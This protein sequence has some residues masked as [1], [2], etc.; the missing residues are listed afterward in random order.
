MAGHNKVSQSKLR[1]SGRVSVRNRRALEPRILLDAAAAE[2]VLELASPDIAELSEGTAQGALAESLSSLGAAQEAVIIDAAV[3]GADQLAASFASSG[4]HVVL[5][6]AE[7]DGVA[8]L[9]SA[10][11]NL[12]DLSTI[13]I[14]SHGSDG[15]IRL[16]N[17]L[18]NSE[19]LA[20]NSQALAGIG[21]SLS[22]GGDIR[23]YG[24]NVGETE[25]GR[26]FLSELATLS[27]ADV[28]ASDDVTG[29][30]GDW[31]LEIAEGDIAS[32]TPSLLGQYMGDL[33]L[34]GAASGVE[35][36][37]AGNQLG[38][39]TD[40]SGDWVVSGGNATGT[41]KVWRV[42]DAVTGG[43]TDGQVLPLPGT[44]NASFGQGVAIF[45]EELVVAA[46]T[47]GTD[48]RIYV[49]QLN[50][51]TDVWELKADINISLGGDNIGPWNGGYGGSQYIDI[52]NGRIIVGAPNEGNGTGRV[53]WFLDTS[54]DG[55][56]STYSSN[57]F[58]EPGGYSTNDGDNVRFGASLSIAGDYFVVG[59]PGA[60]T[61]NDGLG[62]WNNNGSN[63]GAAFIYSWS[64]SSAAAGTGPSATVTQRL[65]GQ[66]DVNGVGDG[67]LKENSRFGAAVDME[68]YGGKY[69]IVAGAPG[70]GGGEIYIYQTTSESIATL[71]GASNIYGQTT[72]GAADRYGSQV[73]VSQAR[74]LVGASSSVTLSNTDNAVWYY[75]AVDNTWTGLDTNNPGAN[76]N[77][78][79][80]TF[81]AAQLGATGADKPGQSIALLG[82]SLAAIGSYLD[83]DGGTN[84]G[85][86]IFR[87]MRT[88]FAIND[89]YQINEDTGNAS[90]NITGNDLWGSESLASVNFELVSGTQDG[91]GTFFWNGSTLE[92]DP[93][94]SY[95]YLAAGESV[96]VSIRYKLTDTDPMGT[97]GGTT[98]YYSTQGIVSFT[99]DGVN[100]PVTNGIG[101]PDIVVP[102]ANEPANSTTGSLPSDGTI[103]IRDNVFK[104]IDLSDDFTYT[105]AGVTTVSGTA[106]T[107]GTHLKVNP[108]SAFRTGSITYDLDGNSDGIADIAE[109]TVWDITVQAS[110]GVTTEFTTFRFTVARANE[111]PESSPIPNQAAVEDS[112]FS[113]DV[114]GYFT[115]PDLTP[116][117]PFYPEELTF[118]II[119]RVGP[120][121]DWLAISSSGVLSGVP[122]NDNALSGGVHTVTIRATDIFGNYTEQT[123][124]ITVANTND[125]PVLSQPI[126]RVVAEAGSGA[127]PFS[128]NVTAANAENPDGPFFEDID[129]T[130]DTITY[131]AYLLTS[132][133]EITAG[134]AGT[135]TGSW[136]RFNGTTFTGTPTDSLGTVFS[137]RLV[138]TDNHG[139]SSE[140]IFEVGV[141]PPVGDSPVV[142]D[143]GAAGGD[144]LGYSSTISGDGR[145]A[146][147]GMPGENNGNGAVQIFE[148]VAGTW[149]LRQTINTG[150]AAGSRFGLSVSL[151]YDGN[152]LVVGAPLEN[153][154][155]GAIYYYERA[156]TTFAAA[157]NVKAVGGQ[158]GERLG[159]SVAVNEAGNNVLAGAPLNDNA[160]GT[161]AGA[162]YWF[163]WNGTTASQ[164]RLATLDAGEA[165]AA[166]DMFGTSVAFNENMQVVGAARDDHSGAVDAG[167]VYVFTTDNGSFSKIFKAGTIRDA[168]YFGASVSVDS[169]AGRNSVLLA[170]GAAGDDTVG[171]NAGAVYI[172]RSDTMVT[173]NGN[174][175]GLDSLVYQAT[176]FAYDA[177]PF[178]SFGTAVSIDVEGDVAGNGIRLAVGGDINA[179]NTGAVYAYRFWDGYG[180]VGQRFQSGIASSPEGNQFG[181]SV[182]VA[183]KNIVAGAPNAERGGA[184]AAGSVNAIALAASEIEISPLSDAGLVK[185]LYSGGYTGTPSGD[186][187]QQQVRADLL[188]M[189]GVE[190]PLKRN[191]VG[192]ELPTSRS[193]VT[194]S[195]ASD[196]KPVTD[197]HFDRLLFDLLTLNPLNAAAKENGAPASCDA[198]QQACDTPTPAAQEK[199]Q[200]K[201]QAPNGDKVT[202]AGFGAQLESIQGSRD[203]AVDS[204]IGRLAGLV[205]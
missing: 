136:I 116:V 49:Y 178:Q 57:S 163:G 75:E 170:V 161:N 109:N 132:G 112:V 17:S 83:D 140:T 50:A 77:I 160:R 89:S 149:T 134:S 142:T 53:A 7:E 65:V 69:T 32:T 154:Q 151:D 133:A 201:A 84:A 194:E 162:A 103:V 90:Y 87:A 21:A 193:V 187:V 27:G 137:V 152:R 183:G 127:S 175:G 115:D 16:G 52:N 135:G 166:G 188:A 60:D 74:I 174:G 15:V 92:Y 169:F 81:T 189:A 199:A 63:H 44:A 20:G 204:L 42:Q 45:G 11:E 128:F 66:D 107:I 143:G 67:G 144:R 95:Q 108:N 100:D 40:A 61:Y 43:S 177:Q 8:Q 37:A 192:A 64:Q 71:Q 104:D 91:L 73:A 203:E 195:A 138:A 5:L 97:V 124:D 30:S 25:A 28:A 168:D 131:T 186:E 182:A 159:T 157:S 130:G 54:E 98:Y 29:I 55:D 51:S 41:V 179:A 105:I 2:T 72:S 190:S 141:F 197:D 117:D 102:Q 147:Y 113:A 101:M 114:A 94:T 123:F 173:D 145:W 24:C 155:R 96:T 47:A 76:P 167:S 191:S 19:S 181:F 22:P 156:T 59:A 82:G 202:A 4:Y 3:D 48:G 85:R 180:W 158:V 18:L 68:F 38:W 165:N 14:V 34:E 121:P 110:D 172:Y 122:N 12:S 70:E 39:S 33:A 184:F 31:E 79:V 198:E 120:G 139:A 26:A 111:T 119:S 106:A 36:G 171:T 9:S 146:V 118:S 46:P 23:I 150:M 153:G 196:D 13:H 58:N 10:L 78:N 6:S 205:A 88:P 176:V 164:T 1:T 200:E 62:D 99:I 86:I 148:N 185:T 93:G 126:D 125:A 129:P 80:Y 35:D 56:W